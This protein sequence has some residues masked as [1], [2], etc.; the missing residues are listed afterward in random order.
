[1]TQMFIFHIDLTITAAMVTENDHQNRLKNRENVIFDR[2][3][4]VLQTMFF[5]KN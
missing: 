5:L 1:M 3:L 2:N 4:E